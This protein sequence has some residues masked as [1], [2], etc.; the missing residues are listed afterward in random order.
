MLG[1]GFHW[2]HRIGLHPPLENEDAPSPSSHTL[3]F[4]QS[5]YEAKQPLVRHR[6]KDL[7]KVRFKASAQLKAWRILGSQEI[8]ILQT[9]FDKLC[10]PHSPRVLRGGSCRRPFPP[11]NVVQ[12]G[13]A[14]G[15]SCGC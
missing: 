11:G 10:S 12:T 4:Y 5:S 6:I 7:A 8:L 13:L 2:V 9:A 15:E 1:S 3:S 14:R